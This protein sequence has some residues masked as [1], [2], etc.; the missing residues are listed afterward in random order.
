MN[1]L[2][3]SV[4]LAYLNLTPDSRSCVLYSVPNYLHIHNFCLGGCRKS[5]IPSGFGTFISIIQSRCTQ[6]K[7]L[8]FIISRV[9]FMNYVLMLNDCFLS[10]HMSLVSSTRSYCFK[11]LLTVAYVFFQFNI[12][13]IK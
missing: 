9:I 11:I 10:C 4:T 13:I 1:V 2:L 6:E 7:L 8:L 3:A 12:S 5:F